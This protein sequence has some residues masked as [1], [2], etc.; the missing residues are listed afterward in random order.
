[1]FQFARWRSLHNHAYPRTCM[2]GVLVLAILMT[3]NAHSVRAEVRVEG[4]VRAVRVE[5]SQ[6]SVADV[7]TALGPSFNVRFR[8]A[9]PLHGVIDGTF[10]G[11]LEQVIPKLLSGYNYV[12]KKGQ[13]SIELL[14]LGT[15]GT[16]AVFI[17]PAKAPAQESLAKQWRTPIDTAKAKNP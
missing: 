8:T 2:A 11:A 3:V 17:E 13:N 9:M 6:A 14:I 10:T 5:A 12:L 15:R 1:M 16:R 4:D 7:L